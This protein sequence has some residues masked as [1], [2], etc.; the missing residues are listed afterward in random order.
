MYTLK[1]KQE[2]A[3]VFKS[4]DPLLE[5]KFQTKITAFYTDGVGEF[6]GLSTYLKTQ[7]IEILVFLPYTPQRVALVERRH[8]HVVEI[9]KALLYQ[10]LLLSKFWSFFLSP[11]IYVINQLPTPTLQTSAHKKFYS[12]KL[13]NLK[14]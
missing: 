11:T 6:E 13:P 5:R 8:R 9:A 10:A 3:G 14:P 1:S 4:S 7:G 2:V 12:K